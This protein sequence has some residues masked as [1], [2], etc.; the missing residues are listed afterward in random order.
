MNPH[1][2]RHELINEALRIALWGRREATPK[3]ETEQQ[4]ND[5][6][7]DESARRL[8][9]SLTEKEMKRQ[10]F[11]PFVEYLHE[12]T[13]TVKVLCSC[14]QHDPPSQ[15]CAFC[16]GEGTRTMEIRRNGE[17]RISGGVNDWSAWRPMI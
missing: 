11:L 5:A 6:R 7:L 3:W 10:A 16:E 9:A 2:E 1:A 14:Q 12:V 13:A 8:V 15:G 17:V 4:E